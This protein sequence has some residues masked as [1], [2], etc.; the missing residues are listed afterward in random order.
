MSLEEQLPLAPEQALDVCPDG[1]PI[2]ATAEPGSL[3]EM[4]EDFR[5]FTPALLMTHGS[6]DRDPVGEYIAHRGNDAAGG[7]FCTDADAPFFANLPPALLGRPP[8]AELVDWNCRMYA[9]HKDRWEDLREF[10]AG[11]TISDPN[12]RWAAVVGYYSLSVVDTTHCGAGGLTTSFKTIDVT[13]FALDSSDATVYI[14][15]AMSAPCGLPHLCFAPPSEKAKALLARM[16]AFD[17]APEAVFA[18]QKLE[19]PHEPKQGS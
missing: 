8:F 4:R 14:S 18:D 5:F 9:V 15:P 1:N 3:F 7:P 12:R 2:G 11:I 19:L 10:I 16:R 6:F 13:I 17:F